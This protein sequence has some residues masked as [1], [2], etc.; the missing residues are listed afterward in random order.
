MNN[1]ELLL[2]PEKEE[3]INELYQS[4]FEKSYDEIDI[5][6]SDNENKDEEK[7]KLI[8]DKN[9]ILLCKEDK[10]NEIRINKDN[11]NKIKIEEL[12]KGEEDK[13]FYY[14]NKEK[15]KEKYLNYLFQ[16][17]KYNDNLII[18]NQNKNE[19]DKLYKEIELKHPRIIIDR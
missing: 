14:I 5:I 6:F 15:L 2:I 16:Q 3:D 9:E 17:N 11:D 10:I 13:S 18:N 7:Y 8:N 19:M 12:F 4:R 1:Q